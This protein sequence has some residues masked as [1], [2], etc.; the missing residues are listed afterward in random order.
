MQ[1]FRRHAGLLWVLIGVQAVALVF[2]PTGLIL[3]READ[4]S[5]HVEFLSEPCC[6]ADMA[7]SHDDSSLPCG[8]DVAF[9][10]SAADCPGGGCEHELLD[11]DPALRQTRKTAGASG[12]QHFVGADLW[13]SCGMSWASTALAHRSR[14]AVDSIVGPPGYAQ[15]SLCA[16]VLIL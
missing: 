16:T 9:E 2:G 12:A 15:Q 1:W 3:C 8:E 13:S 10:S 7:A 4:G 5:S 6:E 14:W 11:R